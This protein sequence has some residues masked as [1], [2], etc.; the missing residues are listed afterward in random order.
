[1]A[2]SYEFS[3]GSVRAKEK[4]LFS[5]SDVE[6]LLVLKSEDELVRYLKDKGY[7]EGNTVDEIIESSKKRMWNYIKSVAPDFNLFLPFFIQNDVHNLKTVL[8]GVMSGKKYEPLIIEPCTIKP[9]DMRYIVENRRF[10][11]LPEWLGKPADKAYQ[12]LAETKDA[13]NSDAIIDRAVLEQL[14][15]EGKNSRSAF[16]E[17][18]F[19]T[20]VFYSDV[21]IAIRGAKA[22]VQGYFYEN[23]LC[24]CRGIDKKQLIRAALQGSD[25][26]VKYLSK[27]NDFG[28]RKSMEIYKQSTSDLEK[29]IDNRLIILAKQFCRMSSEGPEPLVGYYIGC[30]YE[31]KLIN[32]IASGIKTKTPPD[33]IRERLREIYG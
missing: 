25:A 19:S 15:I 10:D 17:E 29:F 31:R 18:Y 32:I 4:S 21:K 24:E 1:M 9:E 5:V 11:K 13:R 28:C 6:Q 7:G 3:I 8:K 27:I 22:N 30:K 14:L 16:L 20:L 33:K 2:L 12:L 23:A 26:V